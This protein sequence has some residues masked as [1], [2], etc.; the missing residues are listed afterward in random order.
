MPS[1][2]VDRTGPSLSIIGL[3]NE[4]LSD[5]GV[6]I[7]AVRELRR[8]RPT[9]R[10]GFP[11]EFHELAVGGLPLLDYL[12]GRS[13]CIIIDAFS[14]GTTPPGTVHR[15]ALSDAWQPTR[16]T[17]SH[18]IDLL[19]V[20][21]L[22]AM[23]G[24]ETPSPLVLY[25]IEGSDFTTFHE[26]CT[27]AVARALPALI[28]MVCDEIDAIDRTFPHAAVEAAPVTAPSIA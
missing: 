24:G 26:G 19:Q 6:G 5:D 28:T 9:L 13:P 4:L 27:E 8:I 20:L 1:P 2:Q 23:L 7:M 14:T 25:G 11:I 16:V 10:S 12:T 15:L 17:T 22:A 18:Q 21:R 3:G